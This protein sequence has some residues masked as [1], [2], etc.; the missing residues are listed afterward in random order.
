MLSINLNFRKNDRIRFSFLY[1]KNMFMRLQI[2]LLT[3]NIFLL[4]SSVFGAPNAVLS[5][6]HLSGKI[7]DKA[8]GA[9]LPGVSV[10]FPGLKT[11]AIT[12]PDGTF[13]IDKLPATK[14]LI[15]VSFIG[16]KM[17]SEQIDLSMTNTRDFD[18]EESATEISEVVVTGRSGRIQS[19]RTPSPVAVVPHFQLLQNS[20]TNIIDALS[21]VPGIS[22]VTSG[23]GI[24]NC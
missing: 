19:N 14:L 5:T 6:A 4:L 12:K 9:T 13:F 24:S 15:Q 1:H 10:Y 17:Q 3:G 21:K 7:T 20:A 22:Q 18:L 8:S 2:I 23:V 11:G 16:Y